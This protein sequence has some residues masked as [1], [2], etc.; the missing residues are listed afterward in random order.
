MFEKAAAAKEI[1]LDAAHAAVGLIALI[2][3]LWLDLSIEVGLVTREGAIELC[4]DFIEQ[5][6]AE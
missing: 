4:Q 5:R 3:G 2:D 1:R 6:L